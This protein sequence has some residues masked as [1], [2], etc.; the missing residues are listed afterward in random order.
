MKG[1]KQRKFLVEIDDDLDRLLI[2]KM[3]VSGE[4]TK[5]SLRALQKSLSVLEAWD[6]AHASSMASEN[7]PISN[8][9]NPISSIYQKISDILNDHAEKHRVTLG[10]SCLS[11]RLEE[12]V[13]KVRG[14][15]YWLEL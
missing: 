5:A 1:Q 9:S 13:Q 10:Q 12:L 3:R 4:T 6:A 11:L 8:A 14:G 2:N 15:G 7:R